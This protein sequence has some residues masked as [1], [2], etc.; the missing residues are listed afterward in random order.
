MDSTIM[1][2]KHHLCN[3]CS[4]TE[5]TIDLERRM[6]IKKVRICSALSPEACA[7]CRTELICNELVCPV[8]IQ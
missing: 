5:V 7:S 4:A 6:S 3:T 2:L 1:A 8:S